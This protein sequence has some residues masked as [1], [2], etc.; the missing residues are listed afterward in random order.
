MGENDPITVKTTH[1]AI[2]CGISYF[3]GPNYTVCLSVKSF[4]S[5]EGLA[6]GGSPLFPPHG[7]PARGN[8][9]SALLQAPRGTGTD[10]VTATQL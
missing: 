6:D 1:D 2:I 9:R 8:A 4:S 10:A 3:D 7:K 5:R